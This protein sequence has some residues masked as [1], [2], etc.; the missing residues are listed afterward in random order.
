MAI[1]LM[2]HR[3]LEVATLEEDEEVRK[4]TIALCIALIVKSM[5]ILQESGVPTKEPQED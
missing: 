4:E 1:G 3:T 2:D 5:D